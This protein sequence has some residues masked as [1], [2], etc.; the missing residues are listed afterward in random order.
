MGTEEHHP[1]A[2]TVAALT[3][4]ASAVYATWCTV[5]AFVGGRLPIV[6]IELD[7]SFGLGIL[8]VIVFDPIVVTVCYWVSLL[9]MTPFI[10]AASG[11]RTHCRPPPTAAT[12]FSPIAPDAPERRPSARDVKSA[13]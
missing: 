2:Q 3:G 10:A 7:G 5:I 12:S 4:L 8:W 9:P 13:S 6:G 11:R 1:V